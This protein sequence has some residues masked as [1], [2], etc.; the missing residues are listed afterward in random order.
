MLCAM[1]NTNNESLD[2]ITSVIERSIDPET[3]TYKEPTKE[4]LVVIVK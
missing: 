4:D 1:S 2:L 3:L